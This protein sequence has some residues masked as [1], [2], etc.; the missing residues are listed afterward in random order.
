M[1]AAD[2]ISTRSRNSRGI[3]ASFRSKGEKGKSNVVWDG[4]GW[5]LLGR[6]SGRLAARW[7]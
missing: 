7:S 1:L 5:V 2:E 3:Y 4:E 6:L